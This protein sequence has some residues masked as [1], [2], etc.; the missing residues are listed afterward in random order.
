MR[1]LIVGAGA[2]G[3]VFGACLAAGGA[4][5]SV[6]VRPR[7]ADAALAG[8]HLYEIFS[9]TRRVHRSFRPREV[10][11]EVTQVGSRSFDQIWLCVATSALDDPTLTRLLEGSRSAT[12]VSLQPGLFARDLLTR[13]VD[14][15]RIVF[16]VIGFNSYATP[17]DG[18]L[19]RYESDMPEGTAFLF[20]PFAASTFSGI[21]HRV[22]PVVDALHMGKLPARSVADARVA[23]AF[24]SSLLM[25]PIAALELSG[26]SVDRF[27]TDPVSALAATAVREAMAVSEAETGEPAPLYAALVRTF[28]LRLGLGVLGPRLAPFDLES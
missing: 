28:A 25:P 21:E 9:R 22:R 26:W 4:E 20:P 12:V 10:L 24:S 15:H 17:L 7:Y 14:E 6:F 13:S 18:S 27:R 5:V 11:T 1:A 3:Q 16:G 23:L 2:V 8:F 19:E